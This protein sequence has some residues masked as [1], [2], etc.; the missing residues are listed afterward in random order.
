M[1][2]IL[3]APDS[4]KGSLSAPEVCQAMELGIREV[5]PHAWIDLCPLADGGEGMVEAIL[6]K[7]SGTLH[8][9]RVMGPLGQ[10]V[11]ALWAMLDDGSAAVIEMAAAAGI[12]LLDPAR[13]DPTITSTFGVGQLIGQA[14]N[15]GAGRIIVGVGGSATVDGG[16]GAAQALGLDFQ[17]PTAPRRPMAGGALA[18]LTKIDWSNR[19]VRLDD[20][21]ILVACDVNNPLL[22]SQG[23]APVYGPQKGATPAQI[24]QL[25]A[26]LANL[27]ALTGGTLHEHNGA[28]AAGGL[29]FGLA[30]FCGARLV[31]GIDLV[32]ELVDFARRID[33]CDLV[34]CGEGKLDAQSFCGKV[35]G[36]VA[37]KAQAHQVPAVAIVG[38]SEINERQL[39]QRGLFA[40]PLQIEGVSL[41]E[42]RRQARQLVTATATTVARHFAEGKFRLEGRGDE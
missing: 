27:V 7:Q 19:D 4:F 3:L 10:E 5:L 17:V 22:G 12:T 38:S 20:V 16:T 42:A 28:G 29:A 9:A 30:A 26:G 6:A 32:F 31:R 21:E 23:A 2:R 39:S 37:S 18:A 33:N 8:N 41:E 15:A 25:E 13:R 35:V 11:D 24:R 1:P 40:Y 14:L 36:A 34:V